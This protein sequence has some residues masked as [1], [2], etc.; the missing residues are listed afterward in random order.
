VPPHHRPRASDGSFD[1]RTRVQGDAPADPARE[2]WAAADDDAAERCQLRFSF[3]ELRG[4]PSPDRPALALR[5]VAEFVVGQT[6]TVDVD[7]VTFTQQ[8]PRYL[9]FQL[10]LP[11]IGYANAN[12]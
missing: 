4:F 7:T 6:L 12:V 2:R 1:P 8:F 10:F 9:L 3:F 11:D 5:E